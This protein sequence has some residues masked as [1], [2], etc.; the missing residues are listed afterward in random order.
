[1][2]YLP[3]VLGGA[4]LGY[5][6][7]SGRGRRAA[8]TDTPG[9]GVWVEQHGEGDG[10]RRKILLYRPTVLPSIWENIQR[11][12][13]HSGPG[14][15]ISDPPAYQMAGALVYGTLS[16]GS[17][18]IYASIDMQFDRD[19]CGGWEVKEIAA[20]PGY[21]PMI[22]DLGVASVGAKEGVLPD[23]GSLSPQARKMFAASAATGKYTLLRNK[24]AIC[25]R[26]K[27]PILDSRYVLKPKLRSAMTK[28]LKEL[29][30]MS[31][32][33]IVA[34]PTDRFNVDKGLAIATEDFFRDRYHS[35]DRGR[36]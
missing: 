33:W 12:K 30:G 21:G 1:M 29:E 2:S 31:E 35:T 20:L 10:A 15:P 23:Q 32:E 18:L 17:P 19:Y 6:A 34:S 27:D 13:K 22:F 28:K 3:Y 5:A 8:I 25:R 24:K 9:L 26:Y 14:M 11:P 16:D 36:A 4:A 7:A